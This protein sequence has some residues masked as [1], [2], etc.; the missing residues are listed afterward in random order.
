MKTLAIAMF[1]FAAS[2]PFVEEPQYLRTP[3]AHTINLKRK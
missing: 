1:L 3:K 2:V